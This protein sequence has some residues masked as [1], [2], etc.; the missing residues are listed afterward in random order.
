[1]FPSP[2][3]QLHEVGEFVEVSVNC[4]VKGAT[5]ELTSQENP[6]TGTAGETVM[7]WVAV[8]ALLPPALLAVRE[9]V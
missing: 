1:V 5:P 7:V 9:T 2:K 6:A 4:T 3:S 8:F